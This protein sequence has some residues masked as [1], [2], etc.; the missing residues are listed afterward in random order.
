MDILFSVLIVL[1]ALAA[2]VA[3]L[4]RVTSSPTH[5]G[6]DAGGFGST[7]TPDI[8][9]TE[10]GQVETNPVSVPLGPLPFMVIDSDDG[11]VLTVGSDSI[12]LLN[13]HSHN[14]T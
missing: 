3:I 8:C 12:E 9:S 11:Y 2:A 1:G 13:A 10:F 5:I 7:S 14:D 6:G 4:A